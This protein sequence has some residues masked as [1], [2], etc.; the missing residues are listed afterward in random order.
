MRFFDLLCFSLLLFAALTQSASAIENPS[1]FLARIY[2][3]YGHDNISPAFIGETGPKRIA[4]KKFIEILEDD[5][6]LTLPGDMGYLDADPICQCQDHQ[7]LVVT[8]INILS[9]DNKQSHAT[10]TFRDFSDNSF[11]TTI[12]FYLVAENGQ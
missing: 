5:Q 12:R 3:T 1:N 8:D 9:N 7:N 4:S 6:A 10:V 11:T 2:T